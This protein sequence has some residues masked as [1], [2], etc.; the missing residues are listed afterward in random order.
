MIRILNL[1]TIHTV[2]ILFLCMPFALALSSCK[3]T[4]KS[5]LTSSLSSPEEALSHRALE[6]W[7]H[8]INGDMEKAYAMED[9]ESLK[10]LTLTQYIQN[11]G[12]AV[13]WKSSDVSHVKL[14]DDQKSGIAYMKIRYVYTFPKQ[15]PNPPELEST[16]AEIWVLRENQWFHKYRFP[17]GYKPENAAEKPTATQSEGAQDK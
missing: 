9:P 10:G 17:F 8:R 15:E 3:E 11:V 7:T 5:D 2:F 6:Y 1:K 12:S 16:L 4:A 14:S 13:Q